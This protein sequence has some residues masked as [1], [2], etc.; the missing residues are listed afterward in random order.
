MTQ[1]PCYK[2]GEVGHLMGECTQMGRFAL[3]NQIYDHSPKETIPYCH[4]VKRTGT[5]Q[6]TAERQKYHKRK[7]KCE[8]G[9]KRLIKIYSKGI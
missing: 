1:V 9:I 7:I 3:G 5:G 4:I 8:I 2:C 6:K